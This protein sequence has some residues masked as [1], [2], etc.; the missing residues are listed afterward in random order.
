MGIGSC[1]R[2]ATCVAVR[3]SA[4]QSVAQPSLRARTFL[5][6][7]SVSATRTATSF[8]GDCA[9]PIGRD[10]GRLGRDAWGSRLAGSLTV[11]RH[12]PG[13]RAEPDPERP[14]QAPLSCG[15]SAP[16]GWLPTILHPDSRPPDRKLQTGRRSLDGQRGPTDPRGFPKTE[17]R[18]V[19]P[20]ALVLK[21]QWANR[22]RESLLRQLDTYRLRRPFLV[23]EGI[24]ERNGVQCRIW[25]AHDPE[26]VPS[27]V[28]LTVGDFIDNLRSSLDY[29]VGEMRPDGPSRGSAFPICR[30]SDGSGG[31]T[32]LSK[33]KLDSVPD[34]ANRIIEELQPYES[35]REDGDDWST[36]R[37]LA[38]LETLWN[39]AKHR[40]IL[41]G[42][43]FVMPDSATYNRPDGDTSE[44][45]FA[46]PTTRNDAEI[47]L[48]IDSAISGLQARFAIQVTLAQPPRGFAEDWPLWASAWPLEDVVN[49]LY[50]AVTRNVLPR[51]EPFF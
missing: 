12:R 38:T 17:G 41:F 5:T 37:A 14:Y 13:H 50:S 16:A 18:L 44:P 4:V 35:R 39:V 24:G 26:P 46:V 43:S 6:R 34:D 27:D 23:T 1:A 28:A 29:L 31:F 47:W 30:Q 15:L 22:H 25:R 3:S 8:A 7:D 20:Q 32:A 51:F 49:H 19:T 36:Y 21:I 40:T 45:G 33:R 2:P 9:I 10:A 11:V 48:P 42:Y